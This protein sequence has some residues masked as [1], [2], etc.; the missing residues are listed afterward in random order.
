MKDLHE[1]G[2]LDVDDAAGLGLEFVVEQGARGGGDLDAAGLALG[3]H[4]AAEVDG[5]APQ[6]VGE[7]FG[8]DD[9]ADDGAAFEADADVPG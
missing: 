5:V 3:F 8:A 1:A 7:F 2:V 4:A 6:I 9:T